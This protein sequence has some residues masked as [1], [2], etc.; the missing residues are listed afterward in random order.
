MTDLKDR[1]CS[2]IA[3][4]GPI[5]LAEYMHICMA[6]PQFGYYR[7]DNPIGRDGDFITAPEISQM[8]GELLGVW[9]AT[10]WQELGSP[11]PFCLAELGP[12]KG[13]LMADMLRAAANVPGFS[14]AV[15]VALVE[16]SESLS[17]LQRYALADSRVA[18][19]S[20]IMDIADLPAIPTIAIA[21][22]FFDVIPVRQYCKTP[23]GWHEL[24]VGLS[25]EGELQRVALATLL[26]NAQL[27][28]NG[29]NEPDGAIF[30]ISPAREAII[31]TLAGHV[32][33]HEGAALVIDYGHLSTGFGDTFQAMRAHQYT[34]PLSVPGEADLTSHVDFQSLVEA[35]RRT[36]LGNTGLST[37]GDF[38]LAMGLLE[39]AGAL[40]Q[41]KN[42][43]RQETIRS[44]V[45]RLASPNQ[46]GDLFKVMTMSSIKRVMPGFEKTR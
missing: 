13:T 29:E 25:P 28:L 17:V 42:Q 39:R 21:N 7:R 43:E 26:E 31:E 5:T 30:E 33:T 11:S 27:P 12:G 32:I 46:M 20:W 15:E 41:D 35:A 24:G 19:I 38:L 3:A 10:V 4:N 16:T 44:E 1:I 45:E 8:F 36:G 22:E 14:D 18:N 23:T 40:G 9:C 6:H 2:L 34:D 37:Q